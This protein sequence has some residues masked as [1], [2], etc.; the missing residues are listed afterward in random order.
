MLAQSYATSGNA[1]LEAGTALGRPGVAE[2]VANLVAF[3]LSDASTFI[4]G[5]VY[6]IDGGWAC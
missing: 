1:A 4:T 5:S 6:S 2:E 3:L